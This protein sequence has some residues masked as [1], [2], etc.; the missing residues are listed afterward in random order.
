[1]WKNPQY[2]KERT[3]TPVIIMGVSG[4]QPRVESVSDPELL[5]ARKAGSPEEVLSKPPKGFTVSLSLILPQR[6]LSLFTRASVHQGKGSN[7]ILGGLLDA[8]SGL[9]VVPGDSKSKEGVT[10]I[11]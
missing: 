5:N 4:H 7:N 6:T 8:G 11:K 2:L 9:T 10:E 3:A 1:M